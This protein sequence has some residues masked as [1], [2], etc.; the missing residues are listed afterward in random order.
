LRGGI[1][2]DAEPRSKEE[3]R[4]EGASFS[5]AWNALQAYAAP[6]VGSP[7]ELNTSFCSLLTPEAWPRAVSLA[8]K[9]NQRPEHVI[10]EFGDSRSAHS[11]C[12]ALESSTPASAACWSWP[13]V[14]IGGLALSTP[15]CRS[16]SGMAAPPRRVLYMCA[17][18]ALPGTGIR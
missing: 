17:E 3:V 8:G 18:P 6:E 1:G 12:P 11:S 5:I 4:M 13:R 9:Q 14:R 2:G 16:G 15:N 7:K 10:S